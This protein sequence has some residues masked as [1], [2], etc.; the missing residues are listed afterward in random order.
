MKIGAIVSTIGLVSVL[1]PATV[2]AQG[3]L[4]GGHEVSL[5]LLGF[6]GSKDKG[7]GDHNAWGYGAG[8]NYFFTENWGVGVDSYADAFTVPYLL[9]GN[10]FFR[11]PLQELSLAPYAFAGVGREWTHAPHGKGTSVAASNIAGSLR[12]RF[13]PMS[14]G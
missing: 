14:G 10:V 3:D 6:Y 7:G 5:D 12:W 2:C 4:F 13:S 8:L 11:Y 1:V 9:N